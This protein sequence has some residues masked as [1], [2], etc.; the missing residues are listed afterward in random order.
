MSDVKIQINSLEALERLI[1]GQTEMELQIK[2]AVVQEFTKK[3]LK[4]LA[5]DSLMKNTAS[6][7]INEIETTFFTSV[8]GSW[9]DTKKVFKESALKEL[10]QHL[11]YKA[12]EQ[13]YNLVQEVIRKT[14][15]VDV[16]TKEVEK[17]AKW[18]TEEL[19]KKILQERIDK[20]VDLKIKEK[21]GIK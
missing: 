14:A 6:A 7:I 4:A 9:G 18:I 3:H 17:Q 19:S 12:K 16:I 10:N 8:K 21:L 13:L 20:L 15:S 5:T 2:G 1:G 11:E